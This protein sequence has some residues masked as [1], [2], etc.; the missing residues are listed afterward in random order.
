MLA[1]DTNCDNL[2]FFYHNFVRKRLLPINPLFGIYVL[3]QHHFMFLMY[4]SRLLTNVC[5]N[6]GIALQIYKGSPGANSMT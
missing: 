3:N 5:A 1:S 6:T 2:G 4:I